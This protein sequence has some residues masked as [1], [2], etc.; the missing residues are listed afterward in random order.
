MKGKLVLV[1]GGAS[2]IASHLVD[3]LLRNGADVRVA[4]DF[5]SGKLENL[6]YPVTKTGVGQMDIQEFGS[7]QGRPQRQKLHK[8]YGR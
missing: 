4:D 1:T 5:S 6:E 8:T 7:L 2:F 3:T